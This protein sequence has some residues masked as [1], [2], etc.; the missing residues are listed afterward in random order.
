MLLTATTAAAQQGL[1]VGG[2]G[3][4]NFSRKN[5]PVIRKKMRFIAGKMIECCD[6]IH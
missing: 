5:L 1:T 2:Y 4:V 6:T 3:E